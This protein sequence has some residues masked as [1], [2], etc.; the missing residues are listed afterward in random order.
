[1]HRILPFLCALFWAGTAGAQPDSIDVRARHE[2]F[3]RVSLLS[4]SQGTGSASVMGHSLLRMQ[5]P[6]AG[7]DVTFSYEALLADG[8]E[9]KYLFQNVQGQFR[10]EPMRQ[11]LQRF[12]CEGR[13]VTELPLRLPPLTRQHL[14]R[15]LDEELH[16]RHVWRETRYNCATAIYVVLNQAMQTAPVDSTLRP[17]VPYAAALRPSV[18]APKSY[19]DIILRHIY[20]THPWHALMWWAVVGWRPMPADDIHPTLFPKRLQAMA[21]AQMTA[22]P[23]RILLRQRVFSKAGWFT[24]LRVFVALLLLMTLWVV[25]KARK[26]RRLRKY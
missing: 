12:A 14:W 9:W 20:P 21:S 3:I 6:S 5:C 13:G 2:D 1:M 15:L 4:V 26:Y 8:E 25:K 19:A 23:S 10:A 17:L 7:V 11:T 16:R 24:P 18:P 22:G